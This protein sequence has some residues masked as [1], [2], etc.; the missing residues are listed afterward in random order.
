MNITSGQSVDRQPVNDVQRHALVGWPGKGLPNAGFKHLTAL[1]HLPDV[2]HRTEGGIFPQ[3]MPIA[4][5][6]DE[7]WAILRHLLVKQTPHRLRQGS[8]YLALFDRSDALK[9]INVI[10]MNREE[11]HEFVY[12]LIRRAVEP[13]KRCQ[14][15]PD[16]HLLLSGL[17]EEPFGYDEFHVT[18][19]NE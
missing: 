11:P 1:D 18:S 15:L 9:G 3:G 13:G 10:G 5:I 4:I 14:M 17:F 6:S 12:V 2:R 7:A 16:F 19:G 8:E